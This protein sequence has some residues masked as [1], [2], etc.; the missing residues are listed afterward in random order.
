MASITL[1]RTP[2]LVWLTAMALVALAARGGTPANSVESLHAG[3][4]KQ[5]ACAGCRVPDVISR[6]S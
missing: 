6:R 2:I 4:N 3:D 5:H 1:R